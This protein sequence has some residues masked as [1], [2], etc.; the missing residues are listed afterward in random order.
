MPDEGKGT[1]GSAGIFG[2][3]MFMEFFDE[4]EIFVKALMEIRLCK[5]AVQ[6][7]DLLDKIVDFEVVELKIPEKVAGDTQ[8]IKGIDDFYAG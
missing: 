4:G 8:K 2:D 6:F 3:E 7:Q 1:E 5:A